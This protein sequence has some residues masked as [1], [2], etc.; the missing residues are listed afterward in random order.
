MFQKDFK[1]SLSLGEIIERKFEKFI[2]KIPFLKGV[3][4]SRELQ[5]IGIFCLMFLVILGKLFY[6]QIIRHSYY[7]TLLNKQHTRSTSIKAERWDIYALNRTGQPVKLTENITLYDVAFDLTILG[8]TGTKDHPISLKPRVI[9]LITPV[10]YKHFCEINGLEKVDTEGCINN[11]EQFAWIEI[12]PKMPELF[13]YGSGAKSPEYDSFDFTGYNE[14]KQT[15]I[16]ERSKEKA[17]QYITQ[18]LDEKIQVWKKERNYLWF[19]DNMEFLEALKEQNFPFIEILNTYYVYVVPQNTTMRVSR[20]QNNLLKFMKKYGYNISQEKLDALFTQQTYKYVKLFSSASPDIANDIKKLKSDHAFE[21]DINNIPVLHGLILEPFVKRYYPYGDLLS[22]TLGYV[23]KNGVAYYGI[24]QYFDESLRGID[25]KIV[26]RASSFI[27][28][29][30]ANDFEVIDSKNGD[31]IYLTIDIGIQKEVENIAKKYVNQF[32]ADAIAV[33]VYDPNNGQIK[34][35][36]SAPTFNPNDYNDAYI[37]EPLGEDKAYIIDDLTYVDVPVY[38]KKDGQYKLATTDERTDQSLQKY[39]AKNT[40]GAQVFV[41]KN[42]SVAFEPGSIFKSFTMA[43]GLDSDEIRLYD[44]YV[45]E[46]QVKIWPYTIKNATKECLGNHNFLHGLVYSCNIGMV[47]IVQKLGKEIFYNYLA[48]LGFGKLT[49]IELAEEKEGFVDN[50]TTVSTARFLNNSFWQGIQVTQV[51]L[52]AAYGVLVNGGHYIKP[53][54]IDSIT[55]KFANSEETETQKNTPQIINQIIR[56]EV[57]EEMKTAL[58]EVMEQ[59][60]EVGDAAKIEGYR[61]GA[62]SWTSQIAYKWRYQRGN[63]WTQGTFVGLVTVDDPK[64]IVLIWT[65]RPRTNQWWGFT[66]GRVFRDVAKFLIGYS[67]IEGEGG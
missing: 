14:Q 20:S 37:L 29:V 58:H 41:D 30:G 25:G 65:S 10:V 50:M 21:K 51:Q 59:N 15:I 12:L 38:I 17:Y 33:M 61:L 39:I 66:S 64:Y 53:T 13:Y 45:D 2:A 28:W 27:G 31:D 49:G 42:I 56:P 11:I 60:S 32:K 9:E 8:N 57:C 22:N 67:L 4:F 55:K 46:G 44:Y 63:G 62:K 23:D 47:R 48:K 7:E 3:R 5:L 19:F 16:D 43:I 1:K 24:E 52:A 54:I 34:A 40:Y 35:S 36:V 18:R 6:V 26:G